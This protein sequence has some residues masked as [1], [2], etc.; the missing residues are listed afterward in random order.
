MRPERRLHDRIYHVE[1]YS[2][3]ARISS[4]NGI[5]DNLLRG[6]NHASRR[7]CGLERTY[8]RPKDPCVPKLVRLIGMN[9]CNIRMDCWYE[10]D[11][12]MSK[13]ILDNLCPGAL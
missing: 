4:N 5:F 2:G 6:D 10:T 8:T 7:G 13:W 11:W 9:Q 3:P 1:G 12:L